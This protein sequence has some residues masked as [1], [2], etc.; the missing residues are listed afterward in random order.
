MTGQTPRPS[1]VRWLVLAL[2]C[3]VSFVAYILRTNMSIAGEAMMKDLGFS[4]MQFGY[5]L[6]AFAWGYG[7]F[8]LP[9]GLFG[10][11]I[12]GGRSVGVL[13]PPGGGLA[14]RAGARAGPAVPPP[15]AG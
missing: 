5:V 12:G 9:G 7:L 8:Q 6:A 4:E 3:L 10:E 2:L 15:W 14:R 1:G 11:K 13:V